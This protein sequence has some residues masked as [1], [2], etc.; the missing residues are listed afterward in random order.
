MTLNKEQKKKIERL[1]KRTAFTKSGK[2][3][4]AV[5]EEVL[6]L[7]D[8]IEKGVKVD[9]SVEKVPG[10][11]DLSIGIIKA[12]QGVKGE[13]GDIGVGAK[14]PRGPKGLKGRPG[15][16]GPKGDRGPIGKPGT[17][18]IGSGSPDKPKQIR[19]K[20]ETLK[21]K[22]RLDA[23]A[24]KNLKRYVGKTIKGGGGGGSGGL[25]DDEAYGAIWATRSGIPPSKV[26][27]Y[28]KINSM[29]TGLLNIAVGDT[30]P[31]N[32]TIGDLWLDTSP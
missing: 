3:N 18:G 8:K 17:Q 30:A 9:K 14:G 32:P 4:D 5:F 11:R 12:I 21:G 24:I 13:K 2:G 22:E 10:A 15:P 16:K 23:K 1:K 29:F 19:D 7:A 25:F 27:V 20:L 26:A 6:N 31:S 28:N